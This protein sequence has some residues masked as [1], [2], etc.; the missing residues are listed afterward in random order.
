MTRREFPARIKVAAY[1]RSGGFCEHCSARLQP[2][3]LHYDHRIPDA[4]GGEPTFDNC[5]VLC[6]NCHAVKTTGEDVPRISKAKRQYASHIGARTSKRPL[7]G[8]R[9]SPFKRKMNGTVERRK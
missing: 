4:L 5:Q 1:E 2:G 7:P 6:T 3:R 9:N 8:G